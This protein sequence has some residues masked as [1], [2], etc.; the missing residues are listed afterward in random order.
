[1][2]KVGQPAKQQLVNFAYIKTNWS[3]VVHG[4]MTS[5]RNEALYLIQLTGLH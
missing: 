3:T 5:K 2:L 1:M 4:N